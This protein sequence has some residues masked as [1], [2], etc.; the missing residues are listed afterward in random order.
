MQIASNII[1]LA[2]IILLA[3]ALT[4]CKTISVCPVPVEERERV[5]FDGMHIA[6][7]ENDQRVSNKK[8]E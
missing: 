2:G 3:V 6:G 8:S 4:A 7:G 1:L 5:E